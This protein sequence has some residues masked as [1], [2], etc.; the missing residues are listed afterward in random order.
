[1]IANIKASECM[2][3]T[4]SAIEF[5]DV[6]RVYISLLSSWLDWSVHHMDMLLKSHPVCDGVPEFS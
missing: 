5:E 4:N 6:G 3:Q 1:M 2:L